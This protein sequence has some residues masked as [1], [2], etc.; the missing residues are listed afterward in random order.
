LPRN[1]LT[2][3]IPTHVDSSASKRFQR[4]PPREDSIAGR[5]FQGTPEEIGANGSSRSTQ[6]RR[7]DAPIDLRAVI[8]GSLGGVLSLRILHRLKPAGIRVASPPASVY[9]IWT[10]LY[11]AHSHVNADDHIG[12]NCMHRRP[13]GGLFDRRH[14]GFGL[15]RLYD[16]ESRHPL[17]MR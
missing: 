17:S 5:R 16:A 14:A 10:L 11:K 4:L 8:M 3:S 2:M 6:P 7:F 12:N 15:R 9:S 13:V 1:A